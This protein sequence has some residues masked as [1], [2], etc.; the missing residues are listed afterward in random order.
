M[1]HRGL[2][3]GPNE[4]SEA[5]SLRVRQAISLSSPEIPEWKGALDKVHRLFHVIPDWITVKI[6]GPG[7]NYWEAAATWQ[8]EKEGVFHTTIQIPDSKKIRKFKRLVSLEEVCAHEMVHAVRCA[9]QEPRFEEILAYQTAEK[10]WRKIL[11]G[12]WKNP[13]EMRLFL[14][15]LFSSFSVQWI[16][17]FFSLPTYTLSFLFLP[18]LFLIFAASRLCRD[19][20]TFQK[21]QKSLQRI[22][23]APLPLMLYLTDQE[24]ALFSKANI[25]EIRAYMDSC[26]D[27]LRWQ[28]LLKKFSTFS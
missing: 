20:R 4:T 16:G 26:V 7:L 17:L 9:F 13:N 25:A 24:I 8:E 12:L 2:V 6:G 23:P 19:Y 14:L 18:W 11:G 1:I 15:L 27:D 5:F 10:P 21:C 3:P 28:F 22:F